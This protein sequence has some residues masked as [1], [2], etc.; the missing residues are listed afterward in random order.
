MPAWVPSRHSFDA[1]RAIHDSPWGCYQ[2]PGFSDRPVPEVSH[3]AGCL[4]RKSGGEGQG[5][6]NFRRRPAPGWPATSGCRHGGGASG[7]CFSTARIAS[8]ECRDR[9]R[10]WKRRPALPAAPASGMPNRLD[11]LPFGLLAGLLLLLAAAG[12]GGLAFLRLPGLLTLLPLGFR[13]QIPWARRN[14]R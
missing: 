6:V 3:W 8:P 2:T 4:P 11:G 5:A 14:R 10:R 9:P 1:A 12:L 7:P 13:R